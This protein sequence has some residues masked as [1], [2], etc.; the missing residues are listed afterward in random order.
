MKN[1]IF[2]I[3]VMIARTS[4]SR[5]DPCRFRLM[6]TAGGHRVAEP[7]RDAP[8]ADGQRN[9]FQVWSS[10]SRRRTRSPSR[11]VSPSRGPA[12]APGHHLAT[13][14]LPWPWPQELRLR[15]RSYVT[16]EV[17]V[18]VYPGVGGFVVFQGTGTMAH[19]AGT[20][21]C[22]C[23]CRGWSPTTLARAAAAMDHKDKAAYV[24]PSLL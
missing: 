21:H 1:S 19:L 16:H 9:L 7:C 23:V 11:E 15:W 2:S 24:S 14:Q 3:K 10:T 22:L 12:E 20:G 17:A 13:L 4:L 18:E 5:R 8:A 6:P